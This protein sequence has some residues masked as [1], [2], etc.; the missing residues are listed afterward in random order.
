MLAGAGIG[1]KPEE[2]TVITRQL[3]LSVD[4]EFAEKLEKL[5]KKMGR[6]MATVLEAIGLLHLRRPRLTSSLKQKHLRRGNS[7]S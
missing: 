7:I 2:G 6:P 4:D 1:D 3:N 5:S